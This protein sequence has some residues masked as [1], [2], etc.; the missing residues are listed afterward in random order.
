MIL[1]MRIIR[2]GDWNATV[3]QET[4]NALLP[5]SPI[6]DSSSILS[7]PKVFYHET[8][9]IFNKLFRVDSLSESNIVLIAGLHFQCRT[10]LQ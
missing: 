7:L 2:D 5:D 1:I 9:S 6:I 8:T 10:V 4:F 3:R